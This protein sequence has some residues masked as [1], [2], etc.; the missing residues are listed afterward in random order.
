MAQASRT[1]Q[2]SATSLQGLLARYFIHSKLTVH[3]D[4]DVVELGGHVD[5]LPKIQLAEQ[6]ARGAIGASSTID[7]QIQLAAPLPMPAVP[8]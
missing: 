2:R 4:N 5:W 3:I 1:N 7:N 6:I 8:E